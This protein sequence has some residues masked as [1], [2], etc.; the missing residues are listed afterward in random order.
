MH[1]DDIEG[2]SQSE[3]DALVDSLYARCDDRALQYAHRWTIGDTLI[4]DNRAVLHQVRFDFD[5][6]ERRYLH[7][8][9]LQGDRPRRYM[10]G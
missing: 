5:P 1:D 4:W 10:G 3:A 2:L 9:M 6:R 7:R 8:I